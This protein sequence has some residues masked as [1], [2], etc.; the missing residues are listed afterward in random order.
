MA[1]APGNIATVSANGSSAWVRLPNDGDL[2]PIVTVGNDGNTWGG[3]TSAALEF[4]PD[5]TA[6]APVP[7]PIEK[8]DV[9]VAFTANACRVLEQF[10]GFVRITV[11]NYS[12]S[13]PISIVVA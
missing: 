7:A 1:I 13:D 4:C 2:Y 12:G 11:T 9:A 6:A 10:R 3:S 8:D 5:A